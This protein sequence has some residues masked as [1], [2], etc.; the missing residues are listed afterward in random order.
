MTDARARTSRRAMLGMGGGILAGLAMPPTLWAKAPP[1]AHVDP[2][3][4]RIAEILSRAAESGA[5]PFEPPKTIPLPA[6]VRMVEVPVPKAPPVALYL[7][8]ERAEPGPDRG[9][10]LYIHGGGFTRGSARQMLAPLIAMARRLDC[11]FAS[12]EYRLAPATPFPGALEDNHAA[13]AW[14]QTNAGALGID[15][16][17][18]ALLGESAGG[19][20]AAMLALSVRERGLMPPG[21][22]AL[23]Y[24]MLDDRTGSTRHV[25]PPAGTLIWTEKDNRAGWTALLGRPAGSRHVPPGSVPARAADL[26]GLPPTWI[27]VGD[28]DLFASEDVEFGRRLIAAG[29]PTE[30]LVVPGAFHGFEKIMPQA[31]VSRRF[32]ASL[33]SALSRAV[34]KPA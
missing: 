19:G 27:G 13:L 28:I 26:A 11:L 10:I 21:F 1:F 20:H 9:A 15:A 33:E 25:P 3:L 30:L 31:G 32:S 18:I 29:V 8:N 17:R 4:R 24:P 23:V 12:V 34:G 14:L 6:G 7:A 2:E 5:P 16:S 22:Q